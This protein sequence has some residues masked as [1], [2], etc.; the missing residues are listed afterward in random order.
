MPR[1]KNLV[2]V[3]QVYAKSKKIGGKT[4]FEYLASRTKSMAESDKKVMQGRGYDVKIRQRTRAAVRYPDNKKIT[5]KEYVTWCRK[6][7]K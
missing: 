3:G 6:R 4:Y 7:G 5:I 1:K 2:K